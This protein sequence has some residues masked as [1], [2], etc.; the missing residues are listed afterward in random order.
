MNNFSDK[1]KNF[2]NEELLNIISNAKDYQKE[3]VNAAITIASERE[4]Y[5]LSKDTHNVDTNFEEEINT[6]F[7]K[8][9][10]IF[11]IFEENGFTVLKRKVK[12]SGVDAIIK[13]NKL[14][15]SLSIETNNIIIEPKPAFIITLII[16]I[17]LLPIFFLLK[18]GFSENEFPTR[19]IAAGYVVIAYGLAKLIQTKATKNKI[20]NTIPEIKNIIS[21][22]QTVAENN[23]NK[24]YRL[25]EENA[26]TPIS[27]KILKT[28]LNNKGIP[29]FLKNIKSFLLKTS[30]GF[31]LYVLQKDYEKA[32]LVIQNFEKDN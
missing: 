2:S 30:T 18:E 5:D 32:I 8:Y 21:D 26:K 12:A 29:A 10:N 9:N 22:Y 11:S 16:F 24:K 19:L 3:A 31:E 14:K 25:I 27:P 15:Y 7:N 1:Y 13:K 23:F 17:L 20:K 4:I 6:N 28:Q